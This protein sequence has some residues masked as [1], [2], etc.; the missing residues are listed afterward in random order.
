[1]R[2]ARTRQASKRL[3]LPLDLVERLPDLVAAEL[4]S[5]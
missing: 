1:M 5:V 2:I 4:A 3:S